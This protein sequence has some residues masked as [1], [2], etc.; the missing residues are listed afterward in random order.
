MRPTVN[1]GVPNAGISELSRIRWNSPIPYILGTFAVILGLIAVALII[2]ACSLKKPS[3]SNSASNNEE[4][5]VKPVIEDPDTEPKIV[6]VR[7]GDHKPT[8]LAK[9][10]PSSTLYT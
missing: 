2:L 6:V 7:A 8:Y 1:N 9:P 4:K 3:S 10:M 5:S